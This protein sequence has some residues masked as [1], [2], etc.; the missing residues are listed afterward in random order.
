[1]TVMQGSYH[2]DA[3]HALDSGFPMQRGASSK[4]RRFAAGVGVGQVI[5]A[6]F[7]VEPSALVFRG[8][9]EA[10]VHMRNVR[11]KQISIPIDSLR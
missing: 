9:P 1:M 2:V 3:L 4:R 7:G 8:P 11:S 6:V 5:D 10:V